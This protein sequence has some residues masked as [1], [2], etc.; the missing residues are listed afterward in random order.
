MWQQQ[1]FLLNDND[2]DDDDNNNNNNNSLIFP[3]LAATASY[4]SLYPLLFYPGL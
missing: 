2:D 3:F 1:F 4:I